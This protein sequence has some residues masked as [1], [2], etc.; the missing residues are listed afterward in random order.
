MSDSRLDHGDVVRFC[1]V[2]LNCEGGF[3][4]ALYNFTRQMAYEEAICLIEAVLVKLREERAYEAEVAPWNNK[5]K[6]KASG[7]GTEDRNPADPAA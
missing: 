1:N 2:F 3:P 6:E 5:A 4:L 7:Q